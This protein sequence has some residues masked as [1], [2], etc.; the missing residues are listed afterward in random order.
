MLISR[1]QLMLLSYSVSLQLSQAVVIWRKLSV[2]SKSDRIPYLC[3]LCSGS[4][5]KRTCMILHAK[6]ISTCKKE[7]RNSWTHRT[8]RTHRI[9]FHR[10]HH[11]SRNFA[12]NARPD[13]EL[14][15]RPFLEVIPAHA[16][17][18]S[19]HAKPRQVA[20]AAVEAVDVESVPNPG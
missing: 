19:W 16:F 6:C 18:A 7:V 5:G 12:S 17:E 1:C 9:P 3:A 2:L 10:F 14:C 8:H 4:C 13:S 20:V 15:S 11:T